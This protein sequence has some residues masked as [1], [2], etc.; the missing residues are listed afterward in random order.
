MKRLTIFMLIFCLLAG[1]LAGCGTKDEVEET[2]EPQLVEPTPEVRNVSLKFA[3][4]Y[5]EVR[6]AL[7]AA[8]QSM[9]SVKTYNEGIRADGAVAEAEEAAGDVASAETYYSGTNVQ[10]SGVDEGDIVK[11]DGTYIYVLRD[12][13]LIIMKA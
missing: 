2:P 12:V 6:D 9:D 3:E 5:E 13:E 10:V 8:R 4:S 1:L 7:K 11:T